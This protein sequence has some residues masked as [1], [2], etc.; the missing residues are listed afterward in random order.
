MARSA[1]N[2]DLNQACRVDELR[3]ELARRMQTVPNCENEGCAGQ[4]CDPALHIFTPDVYAPEINR[5]NLEVL[6][7]TS[8]QDLHSQATPGASPASHVNPPADG[9]AQ[10]RR[11]AEEALAK[12]GLSLEEVAALDVAPIDAGAGSQDQDTTRTGTRRKTGG[13]FKNMIN[14]LTGVAQTRSPLVAGPRASTPAPRLG[15][16]VAVN[17]PLFQQPV[18]QPA[19]V[20]VPDESTSLADTLKTMLQLMSARQEA[21]SVE[22]RPG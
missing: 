12:V 20:E 9:P 16:G 13:V 1:Y 15:P 10:R 19:I 2:L 4:Q 8:Q 21:E 7:S 11:L 14:S 3:C 18:R 5:E 22:L 17:R 6:L